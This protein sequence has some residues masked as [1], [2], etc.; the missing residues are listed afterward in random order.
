M[1]VLTPTRLRPGEIR[2]CAPH[3]S[4]SL[5]RRGVRSR[6]SQILWTIHTVCARTLSCRGS[7]GRRT[8][9]EENGPC[10]CHPFVRGLKCRAVRQGRTPSSRSTSAP[11]ISARSKSITTTTPSP[12]PLSRDK[13][14]LR[15]LQHVALPRAA[16]AR[17]R[18]D[19]R[20]AGRRHAAG[21]GR[22]PGR[23]AGRRAAVDQE[24]RRQLPDAVVQGSRRR[25]GP[26]QGP[27]VRLHDR[28]LR[29]DR[30]PGQQRRRQRRRRRAG[31]LHLRARRPGAGQDPRHQR[32]TAPRSSA[33]TAPTTKS[34]ASARRSRSSTAGASSTSTC[35]RSTPRAP[36]R[37]ASR[38]PSSSA[39]GRR[40][41]SSAR[42]PAAA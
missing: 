40:S 18:A 4:S 35:G 37:S 28:R 6:P 32:S 14:E 7:T 39:G 27:R 21:P 31:E 11:R 33:S 30:Q 34:I 8:L 9:L 41:T 25:R 3:A 5:P 16:A 1:L 2:S 24:R 23:G 17:R 26:E 38:S 20:P 42:W 19:R 10:P 29:L 13:I 12:R 36:R 22:P 15:P